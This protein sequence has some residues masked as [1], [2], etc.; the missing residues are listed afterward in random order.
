MVQ[1]VIKSFDKGRFKLLGKDVW[2]KKDLAIDERALLSFLLGP[3][4]L[5]NLWGISKR[6]IR[7][8][9]DRRLLV[10]NVPVLM[11]SVVDNELE[12]NWLD[13]G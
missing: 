3:R 12:V 6:E 7:V 11:A 5:L 4:R 8:N 1:K 13:E 9:D 10:G 2:C